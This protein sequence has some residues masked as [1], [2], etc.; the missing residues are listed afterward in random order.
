MISCCP[1]RYWKLSFTVSLFYSTQLP[2]TELIMLNS[3]WNSIYFYKE[4][5]Y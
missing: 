1:N 3:I 4:I 5:K 2:F